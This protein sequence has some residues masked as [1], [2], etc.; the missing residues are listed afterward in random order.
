MSLT[1]H[2]FLAGC[3]LSFGFCVTSVVLS[4]DP[5]KPPAS[6]DEVLQTQ[7][8][9]LMQSQMASLKVEADEAGFPTR[10]ATKPIFKY[11]DP[12]RGYVAA[13]VWKLGDQGRPKALIAVELHRAA[14]NRQPSICFE[15]ASLTKTPFKVFADEKLVWS[16]RGTLYNFKPIPDAPEPEG[17]PQLRL[18]QMRAFAKR[19]ASNEIVNN[20]TCELRLLPQP[21]D[22]YVPSKAKQADGAVFFFTFGTNP[23]VVLLIESDGQRWEFAAG[24]LT[25]AEKVVLTFDNKLVWSGPPLQSGLDSPFTGNVYAVDIPGIGPNGQEIPEVKPTR[26]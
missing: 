25:G 21:V 7:R 12:A 8:F 18:I 13:S 1:R 20:E 19:F 5:V 17:T 24:R 22:R 23:E 10:F 14:Y 6:R 9:E 26:P 15:Y 16:P 4:E 11:N 2:G 3:V